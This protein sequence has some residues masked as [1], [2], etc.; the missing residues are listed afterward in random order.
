MHVHF[1]MLQSKILILVPPLKIIW[2]RRPQSVLVVQ[3]VLIARCGTPIGASHGMEV[4][5]LR[6]VQFWCPD[7]MCEVYTS[8]EEHPATYLVTFLSVL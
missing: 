5:S 6:L 1:G 8:D 7:L 3:S 2:W 4:I